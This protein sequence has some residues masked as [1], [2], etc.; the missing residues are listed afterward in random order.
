MGGAFHHTV[1]GAN[2]AM[3]P[4]KKW[5]WD[6]LIIANCKSLWLR[7]V[8]HQKDNPR[9]KQLST[10]NISVLLIRERERVSSPTDDYKHTNGDRRVSCL[11][12]IIKSILLYE[13]PI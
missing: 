3:I 4:A 7:E 8:C 9:E 10:E 12:Y 13:C 11:D 1:L 5:G 6:L 2:N